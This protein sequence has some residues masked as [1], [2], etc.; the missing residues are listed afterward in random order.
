MNDE[1]LE[2][3]DNL[4]ATFDNAKHGLFL[5]DLALQNLSYSLKHLVVNEL[6]TDG[7]YPL[8]TQKAAEY[9]IR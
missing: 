3:L 7:K 9:G 2:Y 8:A 5:E 6:R 1:T 4:I